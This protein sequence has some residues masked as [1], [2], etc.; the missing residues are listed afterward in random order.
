MYRKN[1]LSDPFIFTL[2]PKK[3]FYYKVS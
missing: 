3:R 2:E 1:Q